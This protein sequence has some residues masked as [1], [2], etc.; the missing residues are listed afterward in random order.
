MI[1]LGIETSCDETAVAV[2]H[3]TKRKRTLLS[4]V[5]AS[6]IA[7]HRQYG[8]V[9][10]E[11]AAREHILNIIP[12][13]DRALKQ[14]H[15]APQALSA[16]AVT[17]G[18]GLVTSLRVGVQT[19]KTLSLAWEKRL[20]AVNH[21]EGHLYANWHD[22][23][24]IKFPALCLIVSGGHTEL[25]LVTQHGN[26]TLIG[27]T[28]D[29]AA[30]EAFDKVAKILNIGYP[31]GPKIQQLARKGNP[32]AF[33]LPRPMLNRQGYDFSFSGLKTA[34][35][36]LI[37]NAYRGKNIPT[38]DVCASFQQAVIDVLVGKTV[39][40]AMEVGAR[41]VLLAGGVAANA[42][43]REQLRSAVGNI[44][45]SGLPF[46]TPPIELC[47]DNAGMIAITG[48]Y[49]ALRK[50]YSAWN[51]LDAYPNWELV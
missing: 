33:D 46:H 5:I 11:V 18:P 38:N 41:S 49:R 17:A 19:A 1:I 6:Q 45:A 23:T 9:V 43:L 13:L 26:H 27:R 42:P 2:L 8:G 47:T 21:I 30:G 15:I 36:Y 12:C 4:H 16:I 37:K 39:R 24:V 44:G 14:A 40:A 25:V 7:T 29:D 34:V 22:S 28:R 51:T 10:P 3:G 31:G 20:V 50:R 35:L 32:A 48:Y